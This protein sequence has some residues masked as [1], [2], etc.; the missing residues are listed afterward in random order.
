MNVRELR[1]LMGIVGQR[2]NFYNEWAYELFINGVVGKGITV[3]EFG[4]SN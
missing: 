4:M 2:Y 1:G 3:V